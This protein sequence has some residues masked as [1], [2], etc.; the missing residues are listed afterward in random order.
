MSGRYVVVGHWIP[1]DA[2]PEDADGTLGALDEGVSASVWD[3][4]AEA[5]EEL[6]RDMWADGVIIDRSKP[7]DDQVIERRTYPNT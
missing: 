7:M 2:E 1:G 6:D 5:R 4:L 3:T